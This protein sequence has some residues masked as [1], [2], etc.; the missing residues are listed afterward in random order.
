M[1]PKKKKRKIKQPTQRQSQ[2]QVVNI[3]FAEKKKKRRKRRPV[4]KDNLQSAV[5][6]LSSNLNM[7]SSDTARLNNL[8]NLI[9]ELR[10]EAR[11]PI[12]TGKIN[13]PPTTATTLPT[14][15]PAI[16]TPLGGGFI[17][18][19]ITKSPI[20]PAPLP[21]EKEE[22][23]LADLFRKGYKAPE[24][25]EPIKKVK[26]KAKLKLKLRAEASAEKPRGN[27]VDEPIQGGGV[28]TETE[29]PVKLKK[30]RKEYNT[31]N[32]RADRLRKSLLLRKG[33]QGLRLTADQK[34]REQYEKMINK[35][36]DMSEKEVY[37]TANIDKDFPSISDLETAVDDTLTFI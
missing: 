30:E 1:P 5:Q 27:V 6:T 20:N 31:R 23:D 32:R 22:G 29:I 10:R 12:T 7:F 25:S 13:V 34:D 2:K 14:P 24:V 11:Q 37:P 16:N 17:P 26:K 36:S 21:V 18:V 9:I 15:A 8:E 35:M 19:P 28:D 3:T 33:I 4:K